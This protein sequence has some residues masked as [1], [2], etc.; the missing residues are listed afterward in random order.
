MRVEGIDQS[1]AA[2]LQGMGGSGQEAAIEKKIQSLKRELSELEKKDELSQDEIKKKQDLQQQIS[3]LEQSGAGLILRNTRLDENDEPVAEYDID[4]TPDDTSWTVELPYAGFRYRVSLV[5]V[6][7]EKESVI[8]TSNTLETTESW[9]A[10][11]P[12]A[13]EDGA[14]FRS[15]FS[16]LIMKGGTVIPNRQLLSLVERMQSAQ[17]QEADAR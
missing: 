2:Q 16:S 11:H 14:V 17:R 3:E 8:C 6:S 9:F 5:A 15:V 10:T 12:D 13:L 7:G 1:M 4:I